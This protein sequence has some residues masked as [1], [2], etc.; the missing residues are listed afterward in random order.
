MAWPHLGATLG[1]KLGNTRNFAEIDV[2]VVHAVSEK[3]SI[4]G[5]AGVETFRETLADILSAW[6]RVKG[7]LPMKADHRNALATHWSR[8]PVIRELDSGVASPG[9]QRPAI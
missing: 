6:D 2:R 8:V 3:L 7:G 4:G 9:P 1:L 5:E